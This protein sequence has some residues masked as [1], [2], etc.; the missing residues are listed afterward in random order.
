MSQ[1]IGILKHTIKKHME[2]YYLDLHL[3]QP[4]LFEEGLRVLSKVFD[5]APAYKEEKIAYIIPAMLVQTALDTHD[6][7]TVHNVEK[8]GEQ[9]AR[10]TQLTV[11]A[12][13]YYSG[14]YYLLLSHSGDILFIRLL[15][16]AIK[17]INE[18]K[19]EL[20]HRQVASFTE[21]ASYYGK[22]A[23]RIVIR[24]AAFIGM[25]EQHCRQIEHYLEA[26]SY[27]DEIAGSSDSG[28]EALYKLWLSGRSDVSIASYRK[29]REAR[30][31]DLLGDWRD[32]CLLADLYEEAAKRWQKMEEKRQA[33]KEG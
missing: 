18:L 29:G 22:I 15:A 2:N 7:I 20:Y 30:L 11:L 12:G 31:E 8:K 10:S 9:A 6:S 21:F 5:S 14:L 1:E 27:L 13:D 24:V 25:D 19:M 33:W 17:E 4:L 3:D 26:T 28:E 16:D 23:S 32:G